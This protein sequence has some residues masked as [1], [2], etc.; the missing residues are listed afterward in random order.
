MISF[1]LPFSIIMIMINQL[2]DARLVQTLR[3]KQLRAEKRAQQLLARPGPGLIQTQ[4]P[5]CFPLQTVCCKQSS[6]E[7]S[8]SS[9]SASSSAATTTTTQST[10]SPSSLFF[11]KFQE[12][13]AR[14]PPALSKLLALLRERNSTGLSS[15]RQLP[16]ISLSPLTPHHRAVEDASIDE[17]PG[18]DDEDSD[19][20][21]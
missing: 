16:Q 11:T 20:D 6:S 13:I 8:A 14:K 5:V 3:Q 15:N 12:P 1:S 10:E 4:K 18:T 7:Y 19:R 21:T 9:S 17:V 2:P